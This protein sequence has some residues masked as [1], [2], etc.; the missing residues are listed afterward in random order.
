MFALV[1]GQELILGPIGFNIKM[2]NYE[3]EELELPHRVRTTDYTQVPIHFTDE[4]HILSARDETPEYDPRFETISQ[5]SHMITDT[6]VIFSYIKTE[7]SLEQIKAERKVEVAPLRREKESTKISLNINDTPIEVSTNRENRLLFV[8]KMMTGEGPY[9][10][11]FDSEVW[12]EVTKENL[13]YIISQIDIKVQEAFD[14]EYSKLQEID[15]CET[16]EAVYEVIIREPITS[17]IPNA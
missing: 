7:K 9:N 6:E 17:G 11:K 2:I 12:V 15:A 16:K 1:N 4:V 8:S 5:S 10:F 3:L 14:W 13:Q